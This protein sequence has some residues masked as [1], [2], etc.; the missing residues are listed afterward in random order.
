MCGLVAKMPIAML[1]Q[2]MAVVMEIRPTLTGSGKEAMQNLQPLSSSGW[3]WQTQG[4]MKY[5]MI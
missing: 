4:Q 3:N 5:D 2:D 1:V